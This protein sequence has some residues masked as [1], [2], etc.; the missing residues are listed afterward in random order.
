[1]RAYPD[2][3]LVICVGMN[4]HDNIKSF[5]IGNTDNYIVKIGH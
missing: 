1:M 3:F 4:C 2:K 5:T